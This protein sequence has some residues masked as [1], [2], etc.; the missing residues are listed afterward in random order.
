MSS[1]VDKIV[2]DIIERFR[3]LVREAVQRADADARGELLAQFNKAVGGANGSTKA[4]TAA[5][6]A[7]VKRKVGRPRK[8]PQPETAQAAPAAEKPKKKAKAKRVVSDEV[9]QKL[10]DNL[11]KAREAKSDKARPEGVKR[12]P[13]RPRKVQ[14]DAV[15]AAPSA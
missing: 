1:N 7:L 9:R 11:K 10:A 6:G 3:P 14:P 13:G 8:N 12:K 15:A 4:P 2:G 5:V